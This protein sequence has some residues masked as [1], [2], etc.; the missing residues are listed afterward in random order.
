MDGWPAQKIPRREPGEFGIGFS[1]RVL[2]VGLLTRLLLTALL[3]AL[4]SR[5]LLLLLTGLL[6]PTLLPALLAAVLAALLRILVFV[7]HG[8]FRLFAGLSRLRKTERQRFSSPM[9][10][11]LRRAQW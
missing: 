10:G 9:R 7:T 5:L 3:T 4:P 11:Q 1:L 2:A 8:E 6:L